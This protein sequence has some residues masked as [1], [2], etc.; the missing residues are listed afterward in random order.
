MTWVLVSI[1]VTTNPCLLLVYFIKNNFMVIKKIFKCKIKKRK[2]IKFNS[3]PLAITLLPP[4]L[5]VKRAWLIPER[6]YTWVL[7]HDFPFSIP[8]WRCWNFWKFSFLWQNFKQEH[9]QVLPSVLAELHRRVMKA[10]AALRQKDD[11]NET[12][13]QQLK[14]YERRWSEYENKMKSMEETWQRQFTSLQVSLLDS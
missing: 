14:Q 6:T 13:Q 9:I 3:K 2:H 12:L 1:L 5:S 11:E 8:A 7:E 10:E 4:F